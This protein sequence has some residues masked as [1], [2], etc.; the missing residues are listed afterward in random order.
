MA[1]YLEKLKKEYP[2][3][4]GPVGASD[5]TTLAGM[6]DEVDYILDYWKDKGKE[7]VKFLKDFAFEHM[8]SPEVKGYIERSKERGE[9]LEK[10][11]DEFSDALK[12]YMDRSEK[13]ALE[14]AKEYRDGKLKIGFSTGEDPYAAVR[15]DPTAISILPSEG[16]SDYT[17]FMDGRLLP[18]SEMPVYRPDELTDEEID[19]LISEGLD[20]SADDP[21]LSGYI[22]GTG[23]APLPETTLTSVDS[24]LMDSIIDTA[25]AT[26]VD[27][28]YPIYT[29]E[30][31][32]HL[33]TSTPIWDA[34]LW[35]GG[36]G[37]VGGLGM[38]ATKLYNA[39]K[40]LTGKT[41][42]RA[43]TK[44]LYKEAIRKTELGK[45]GPGY[46]LGAPVG[47]REGT[48][49][50]Y[51]KLTAWL[52]G[53]ISKDVD[54]I[55]SKAMG[56]RGPTTPIGGTRGVDKLA[57]EISE[58]EFKTVLRD[59]ARRLYGVA[60]DASIAKLKE[61][62][63]KEIGPAGV[64]RDGVPY[65]GSTRP[66]DITTDAKLKT[67]LSAM[68][69]TGGGAVGI[70]GGRPADKALREA[71]TAHGKTLFGDRTKSV[72]LGTVGG[73][74]AGAY[75]GGASDWAFGGDMPSEAGADPLLSGYGMP[76][77]YTSDEALYGAEDYIVPSGTT[78][79]EDDPLLSGY[80]EPAAG[81]G[82]LAG[83][84]PTGEGEVDPET[85]ETL[86]YSPITGRM[87]G[88]PGGVYETLYAEGYF[89]SD[90]YYAK[91][92]ARKEAEKVRVEAARAAARAVAEE[93][94]KAMEAADVVRYGKESIYY[95]PLKDPES[96]WFD[97]DAYDYA[98]EADKLLGR[99][100][101]AAYSRYDDPGK[102]IYYGAARKDLPSTYLEDEEIAPHMWREGRHE[103]DMLYGGGPAAP[104]Y[105]MGREGTAPAGYFHST[106]PGVEPRA[107]GY[108]YI[109]RY[110][111][112]DYYKLPKET[113]LGAVKSLP[114]I[115]T[116]TRWGSGPGR[117][118]ASALLIAAGMGDESGGLPAV[119]SF[120]PDGTSLSLKG[121]WADAIKDFKV[122]PHF[123]GPPLPPEVIEEMTAGVMP[124]SETETGLIY[125]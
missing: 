85:G 102:R 123:G 65:A 34:A 80:F 37:K 119:Y 96:I 55:S 124:G 117:V 36:G 45:T 116:M 26:D 107:T 41:P 57:Y 88:P 53:M 81:P 19:D 60:D 78:S 92:E 114:P 13:D 25:Y 52:K 113:L 72:A 95:D 50:K 108:G 22:P 63:K 86:H 61:A 98:L 8:T 51:D 9:D 23:P 70:Y 66:H 83:G 2:G 104:W 109:P 49:G 33:E 120:S 111:K 76:E 106:T 79:V 77:G 32:G 1:D 67:Y 40:L 21:L 89:W 7:G 125:T 54:V 87:T 112:E 16:D 118:D 28:G 93:E 68:L 44:E 42:T 58:Y 75:L 6:G 3:M 82:L 115:S 103:G 29:G 121:D 91:E 38:L 43:V 90:E 71:M 12:G 46:E 18:F 35:I 69:K 101:W 20:L 74:L 24:S 14:K 15:A 97:Y 11:R 84:A 10:K 64:G 5:Y 122:S 100:Y 73:A 30:E 62:L 105:G 59:A 31:S 110:Y 56:T 17:K 48:F 39:T 27:A 94:R 4:F 47:K 99:D